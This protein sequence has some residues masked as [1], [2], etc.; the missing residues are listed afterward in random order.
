MNT[1]T[2]VVFCQRSSTAI[3]LLVLLQLCVSVVE[4][5]GNSLVSCMACQA[6]QVRDWTCDVNCYVT[7]G[8]SGKFTGGSLEFTVFLPFVLGG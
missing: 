7:K 2:P 6:V 8:S 1:Q 3:C 5:T 4:P